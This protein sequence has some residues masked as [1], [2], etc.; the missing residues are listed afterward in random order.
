[1]QISK[2]STEQTQTIKHFS[3]KICTAD[4]IELYWQSWCTQKPQGLIIMIHG[5][6]EHSGRYKATAEYFTEHGWSFYACDLRGHG[7]SEDGRRPG[8]VHVDHFDDYVNDVDAI[9]TLA[10]QQHPDVPCVIMGHS[11]GGLIALGYSI[12]HPKLLKGTVIS[13]PGLAAHPSAQ[14]S[15]LL[16]FIARILSRLSPHLLISSK[17]DPN[18]VSRDPKV[19]KA[20]MADPLVS[21]KVSARWY[22][23]IN[24]AM[25]D[26]QNR[27]KQVKLPTLLMQSAA[28]TLVDPK[29]TVKWAADAPVD[30]TEFVL[31]DGLFHE[32][33]NEPEKD[34]VRL[35]VLQWLQKHV[36]GPPL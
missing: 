2:T 5:L 18:S 30:K 29:S 34:K 9:I 31:W 32:M 19:V 27:A 20:Y 6:A 13:S 10:Q 17:L 35:H 26:I 33:F 25:A 4:K 24:E 36:G 11:M 16:G 8:R 15:K 7:L 21:A 28:D 12:K 23:S 22:I 14:P 3:G 1:M